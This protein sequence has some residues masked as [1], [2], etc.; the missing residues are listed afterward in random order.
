MTHTHTHT[1]GVHS[2]VCSVLSTTLLYSI[3]FVV[4]LGEAGKPTL[5]GSIRPSL[6]HFFNAQAGK[7]L[8]QD[9]IVPSKRGSSA[10]QLCQDIVSVMLLYLIWMHCHQGSLLYSRVFRDPLSGAVLRPSDRTI[11]CPPS[12]VTQDSLPDRLIDAVLNDDVSDK[13]GGQCMTDGIDTD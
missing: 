8:S 2:S 12:G 3:F 5:Q 10:H 7:P 6:L 1:H 4:L 11:T 13:S 9:S